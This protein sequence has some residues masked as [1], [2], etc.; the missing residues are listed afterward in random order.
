MSPQLLKAILSFYQLTGKLLIKVEKR[1]V[2]TDL[3]LR[4]DVDVF[5]RDDRL[6]FEA[7]FLDISFAE[8]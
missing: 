3:N 1:F 4:I 2:L 7:Q 8:D 6:Q 5:D